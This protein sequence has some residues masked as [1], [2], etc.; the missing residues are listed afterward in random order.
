M[1]RYKIFQ[2]L[3]RATE[4]RRGSGRIGSMKR[5]TAS[6]MAALAGG[7]RATRTPRKHRGLAAF[8][9]TS[10]G[11][12][13]NFTA[14]IMCALCVVLIAACGSQDAEPETIPTFAE[15]REQAFE[16]EISELTLALTEF[17]YLF[18]IE[19]D[20]TVPV[21]IDESAPDELTMAFLRLE[22]DET[23]LSTSQREA[24][25]AA[26]REIE[27][28][29]RLVY[30]EAE[31]VEK[32]DALADAEVA[33]M[34]DFAIGFVMGQLG[35]NRPEL[36]LWVTDPGD[37]AAL[38]GEDDWL[39]WASPV[40]VG[41]QQ[42]CKV[43]LVD[44]PDRSLEKLR[45]TMVHEYFHCWHFRNGRS[46]VSPGWVV[47]GLATWVAGVAGEAPGV[48]PSNSYGFAED[49]F[50][51]ARAKIYA[52]EYKAAGFFWQ[53]NDLDG[54]PDRL[55]ERIPNI[56]NATSNPRAFLASTSGLP[57][58]TLAQLASRSLNRSRVGEEWALTSPPFPS[59]LSGVSRP[60]TVRT[61]RSRDFQVVAPSGQRVIALEVME[62]IADEQ[63]V[64]QLVYEGLTAAVWV[65]PSATT[66]IRTSAD[67]QDYCLRPPCICD[68]G[69]E[70][71][72]GAQPVPGTELL[73]LVGLTGGASESASVEMIVTPLDAL[74][75]ERVD[76]DLTG[77]WIAE[78][79]AVQ[80]AFQQVYEPIGTDVT[81]VGGELELTIRSDRTL[82]IEY[83]AVTLLLSDPVI[84]EVVLD[85]YGEMKWRNE[86]GKLIAYEL[87]DLDLSQTIP[88]LG[89]PIKITEDDLP[90]GGETTAD[91]TVDGRSLALDNLM[92]SL[93]EGVTGGLVF[94]ARWTRVG[95][96]P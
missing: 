58:A 19:L 93:T 24:I 15:L 82:R 47:E 54:G 16:G 8:Q 7:R 10:V 23:E 81:G 72:P 51:D 71:V 2:T 33:E 38:G 55:W 32:R 73:L 11:S 56:V 9:A 6:G 36:D 34:V 35:A 95:D 12:F 14:Q 31:P 61:V 96:A 39:A 44:F 40:F 78:S 30:S 59:D 84:P 21:T 63:L 80:A 89:E 70:P 17:S 49:F 13:R 85:G 86:G 41:G 18:D 5:K 57:A 67:V 76:G 75:G 53:L 68:D 42:R 74:C 3:I 45:A 26:V 94:P 25:D 50:S 88:G 52:I 60:P 27:D 29:S 79:R 4:G 1:T 77:V 65:A 64:I 87:T 90:S 37:V 20:G 91:Y 69:T 48:D 46:D 28:A 83:D 92:G 66:Q 43:F 62:Q 22:R